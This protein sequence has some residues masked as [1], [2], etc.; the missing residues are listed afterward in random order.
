MSS[1]ERKPNDIYLV[2]Q[3]GYA[4]ISGIT[5]EAVKAG[6]K[7][8][9]RLGK[10]YDGKDVPEQEQ[11]KAAIPHTM[12]VNVEGKIVPAEQSH[13]DKMELSLILR[14]SPEKDT[15]Y[16]NKYINTLT[17]GQENPQGVEVP[18][19][20]KNT[21][22]PLE[23][24]RLVKNE[25]SVEKEFFDNE[26]KVNYPGWAYVDKKNTDN[27]GNAIIRRTRDI[28][29]DDILRKSS[30]VGMDSYHT[31]AAIKDRFRKGEHATGEVMINGEKV[32]VIVNFK[33]QFKSLKYKDQEGKPIWNTL[34]RE[35]S[36]SNA[37]AKPQAND[38]ETAAV[39]ND[40][41]SEKVGDAAKKKTNNQKVAP[42]KAGRKVTR[43]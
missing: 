33:A 20:F 21:Y 1:E 15:V 13:V 35:A 12:Y 10:M 4:G 34:K 18:A 36:I 17:F 9:K 24:Y 11:K 25:S 42:K 28:D 41:R 29:L 6:I 23:V 43:S 27:E 14:Y 8:A 7:E 39:K 5:I 16:W 3:M 22:S 31:R 38:M 2:E 32:P 19:G 40:K 30:L 26:K 37:K